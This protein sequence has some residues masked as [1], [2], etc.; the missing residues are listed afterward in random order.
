LRSGIPNSVATQLASGWAHQLSPE[1]GDLDERIAEIEAS[2]L[3]WHYAR[4]HVERLGSLTKPRPDGVFRLLGGQM[5]SVASVETRL[6]KSGNLVQLCQEFKVQGGALSEVGVNWSTFLASANLASWIRDNIPDIRTHA[7]HNRHEGVAHY[8]PGGTAT[9]ACGELV[10]YT[11]QKGDDFRGL[12][13]WCSTLFYSNPAHRTRVVAAYNVGRQS[14]KGLKTIYQQQVRHIQTH[15]LNTSPSRL[16]LMDFLAQLQVWKSQGDRL[17]IFVDM[18]EHVLRGT[19]ARYL[20]SMGL[21][22]A[23]HQHWGSEE[24]HTFIGGVDPIDG[25]WHTPDLEVST[26]VQLSFHEGLGDHRTV[27]VDVTTQSAIGKHEFRVVR[28]EARRLNSTNTRVRS[29]YINH[30]EGQMAIHRMP[31]RLEAC[32]WS[33]TGFPTTEADKNSMQRLD[34]QMEEMQPPTLFDGHAVQ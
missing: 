18:N 22:E 12:G 8:Q 3:T 16:F 9:L 32:G 25:V 20:L 14:P 17:L 24:P 23:T 26:L 34:I 29:R 27:L 30:L 21:V 6:R 28:P 7:A 13:R 33:I 15:G 4:T 2:N 11:K 31:N 19:V 10:R 5:N 1:F